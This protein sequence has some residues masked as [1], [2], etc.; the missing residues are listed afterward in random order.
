MMKGDKRRRRKQLKNLPPPQQTS[1]LSPPDAQVEEQP[2]RI[3]PAEPEDR[4]NS[5]TTRTNLA[6]GGSKKFVSNTR[7]VRPK[8]VKRVT[9]GK[10]HEEALDLGDPPLEERF[11]EEPIRENI[12]TLTASE[13]NRLSNQ[14]EQGQDQNEETPRAHVC[15][16]GKWTFPNA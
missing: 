6:S 9:A 11:S 5:G 15:A 2:Q 4:K 14:D 1:S 8:P 16:G 7:R 3:T 13:G 12:N 10:P